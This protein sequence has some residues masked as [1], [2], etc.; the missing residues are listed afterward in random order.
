[1]TINDGVKIGPL[2]SSVDEV[3]FR[4]EGGLYDVT[5]TSSDWNSGTAGL[6]KLG[7]DGTTYLL[8]LTAFAANGRATPMYLGPGLYRI[9]VATS[10]DVRVGFDRIPLG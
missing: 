5:Y 3:P 1:M 7:A 9:T 10:T 8:V 2:T 6:Y 4:L